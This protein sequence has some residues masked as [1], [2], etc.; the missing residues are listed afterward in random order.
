MPLASRQCSVGRPLRIHRQRRSSAQ[1]SLT[2]RSARHILNE[3]TGETPVAHGVKRVRGRRSLHRLLWLPR[4]GANGAC[5]ARSTHSPRPVHGAMPPLAAN[6]AEARFSRSRGASS[7]P[8]KKP[9]TRGVHGTK[10][11]QSRTMFDVSGK[12]VT[13]YMTISSHISHS[14]KSHSKRSIARGSFL[15]FLGR[16]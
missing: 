6:P 4:T 14:T 12:M 7:R 9:R 8:Q 1:W 16:D 11:F 3:R 10:R 5:R 13:S 15:E 2:M